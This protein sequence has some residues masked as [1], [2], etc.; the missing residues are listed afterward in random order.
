MINIVCISLATLVK[1][2]L[3]ASKDSCMQTPREYP[4]D[5]LKEELGGF[6]VKGSTQ[7]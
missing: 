1:G 4:F 5:N 2:K 3:C 6:D 7:R